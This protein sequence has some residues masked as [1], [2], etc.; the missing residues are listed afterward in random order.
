[1]TNLTD[2]GATRQP[3]TLAANQRVLDALDQRIGSN[4]YESQG[5]IFSVQTI[6]GGDLSGAANF[7]RVRNTV[8][9]ATTNA[10]LSETDLG[11][12]AFDYFQGSLAVNAAGRLV[13]GYNRSGASTADLNSDGLAD[14][15]VSFM[16]QSFWVDSA[17][18]LHAVSGEMLLKAGLTSDYHNGTIFGQAAVGRQ[19]WGDYSQVT[20]DPNNANRF[21]AIGEFAREYNNAAG[22]HPGGTGGSRWGAYVAEIQVAVPEPSTYAMMLAGFGVVGALGAR[23]RRNSGNAA[24]QNA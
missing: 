15:N 16:A 18:A 23:R 2:P 11:T 20:I 13:I 24:K 6:D 4:V 8:I 3:A 1:M 10:I 14:G 9:N 19:R 12:V 5:K 7:A 21:W 17:G 22:G